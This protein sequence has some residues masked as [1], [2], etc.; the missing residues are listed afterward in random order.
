ML[1]HHPANHS[2]KFED[3]DSINKWSNRSYT[4]GDFK[5]E[6]FKAEFLSNIK[7]SLL[8]WRWVGRR[9]TEAKVSKVVYNICER[10]LLIFIKTD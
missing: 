10:I 7:E 1:F 9:L 5:V 2:G 6:D 3:D 8:E 4:R